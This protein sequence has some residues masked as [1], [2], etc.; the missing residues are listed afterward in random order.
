M[1]T[2]IES[3]RQIIGVPNF[4]TADQVIDYGAVIEYVVASLVLLTVISFVFRFV[5][6]IF[7]R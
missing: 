2:L 4:Y 5:K 6:W 3:L 7:A 1:Q